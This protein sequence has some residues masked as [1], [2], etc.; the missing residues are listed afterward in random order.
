MRVN[1]ELKL[2]ETIKGLRPDNSESSNETVLIEDANLLPDFRGQTMRQVLKRGNDLGLDV[3]LEG[4]GMAIKQEP[5]PG[6]PLDGITSVKVSF[7][8]PA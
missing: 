4:S 1:P 2:V 5:D 3:V 8:P 7:R 6:C